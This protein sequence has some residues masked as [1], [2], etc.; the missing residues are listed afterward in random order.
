MDVSQKLQDDWKDASQLFDKNKEAGRASLDQCLK[1]L[2][3]NGPTYLKS[4]SKCN[5]CDRHQI[6]RPSSVTDIK[7]YG[8]NNSSIL[9][10]DCY[11]PCR[12]LCRLIVSLSN[13]K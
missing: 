4:L 3:D 11:C 9:D 2:K 7:K 13:S 8:W 6:N 12:H 1:D 5:C 10:M